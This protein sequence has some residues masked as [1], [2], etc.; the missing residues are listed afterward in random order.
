MEFDVALWSQWIS[1]GLVGIIIVGSIRGLLI[2]LMSVFHA[3]SSSES[4]TSVVLLI[5][6]IMGMYFMSNVLLMRMNLPLQYRAIIT[7]VLGPKL[8]W[9]FYHRWFDVIF[10]VSAALSLAQRYYDYQKRV[11]ESRRSMKLF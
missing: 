4:S 9:H 1:F 3:V 11:S 5:S 10:L 6:Q 7:E 2:Q 8:E